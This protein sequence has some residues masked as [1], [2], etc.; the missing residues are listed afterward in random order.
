MISNPPVTSLPSHG[1][2]DYSAIVKRPVYDWPGGKRLAVYLALNLEHFAF[3]EGLGAELAPGGPQPD[4]LNYAWRDYG[5]RVGV[6]RLLALFDQLS[7]PASV[8]VNSSIYGHCPEVMQ[9]V[10]ARGD[11]IVGHGRSNA[12]RQGVLDEASE[13]Q[14][15]AEATAV[16]AQ[17]SGTPPRGWL[18]PWISQSRITSDL[19]AEAGYT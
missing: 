10:Q 17:H 11:E 8:L 18:G 4:V 7:L 12:E 15:I 16:I 5:N 2:F 13:R 19:L 14:L 3:G 6:W 9:A 1:R